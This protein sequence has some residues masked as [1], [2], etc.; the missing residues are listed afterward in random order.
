MNRKQIKDGIAIIKESLELND[1]EIS[2]VVG[3]LVHYLEANVDD[4]VDTVSEDLD[5]DS[6][7]EEECLF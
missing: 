2:G 4:I 3:V 1:C 7:T 5:I 6:E